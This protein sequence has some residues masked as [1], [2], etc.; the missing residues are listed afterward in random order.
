MHADWGT[1]GCHAGASLPSGIAAVVPELGALGGARSICDFRAAP[2]END[3]CP[4]LGSRAS[5]GHVGGGALAS[6]GNR[7]RVRMKGVRVAT[8]RE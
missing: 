2:G 3:D 6:R 8:D 5:T 1:A 7:V 4:E